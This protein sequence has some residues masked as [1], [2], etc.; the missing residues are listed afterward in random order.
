[1]CDDIRPESVDVTPLTPGPRRGFLR[2]LAGA[3]LALITLPATLVRA[4]KVKVELTKLDKLKSVGGAM[5]VKIKGTDVLLVRDSETTVQAIN[6]MCTHKKC[7][8]RYKAESNDL[9]CKCHKSAFKLDGTVMAGPAPRPLM[10]YQATLQNDA[11][12][13][14]LPD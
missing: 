8:V 6:P 5:E 13:I 9:F 11:I 1:M 4:K 3:V 2:L 12:V 10:I 14:T 7:K